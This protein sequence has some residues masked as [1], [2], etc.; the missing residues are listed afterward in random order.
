MTD[1]T[2]KRS[3][4]AVL[5][6]I[7]EATTHG[8]NLQVATRSGTVVKAT[9]ACSDI[10][11]SL[12]AAI[13]AWMRNT[14][15]PIP[16][17]TSIFSAGFG[18][19]PLFAELSPDVDTSLAAVI[20]ATA[21][22]QKNSDARQ[23]LGSIISVLGTSHHLSQDT[24]ESLMNAATRLHDKIISR[25][26]ERA[27]SSL[28]IDNSRGRT[29]SELIGAFSSYPSL[30]WDTLRLCWTS[31]A[32]IYGALVAR[33]DLE[34]IATYLPSLTDNPEY[35]RLY[36]IYTDSRSLPILSSNTSLYALYQMHFD[37]DRGRTFNT[38]STSTLRGSQKGLKIKPGKGKK[39][40]ATDNGDVLDPLP[41]ASAVSA[42][43]TGLDEKL[44]T[45]F[46]VEVPMQNTKHTQYKYWEVSNPFAGSLDIA[47]VIK[48]IMRFDTS[49]FGLPEFS[50]DIESALKAEVNKSAR[51][52]L[53]TFPAI[54][55][56][57]W[58]DPRVM[59]LLGYAG[60]SNVS[61]DSGDTMLSSMT[62]LID[63]YKPTETNSAHFVR[64]KS[65][66][67]V[68]V[69]VFRAFASLRNSLYEVMTSF[70]SF[71]MVKSENTE[72]G[73]TLVNSNLF[74]LS[75]IANYKAIYE[76]VIESASS[77]VL[78]EG[79]PGSLFH[80]SR[81]VTVPSLL[82][83]L[84]PGLSHALVL[85]PQVHF[86]EN[87]LTVRRPF[88]EV[89]GGNP[90]LMS[91]GAVVPDS[92]SRASA[93]NRL[94]AA[95][96]T[97]TVV[98]GFIEQ[99]TDDPFGVNDL[100]RYVALETQQAF[101]LSGR[102]TAVLRRDDEL[103]IQLIVAELIARSTTGF[104]DAARMKMLQNALLSLALPDSD[105][106]VTEQSGSVELI[107]K[108]VLSSYA[109]GVVRLQNG[110]EVSA[111]ALSVTG[112]F[113]DT[114]S[115]QF[116]FIFKKRNMYFSEDALSLNNAGSLPW[117]LFATHIADQFVGFSIND[118]MEARAGKV[119]LSDDN[120]FKRAY[121]LKPVL[122]EVIG[123]GQER[124]TRAS[125]VTV[126]AVESETMPHNPSN[127]TPPVS[128]ESGNDSNET[129]DDKG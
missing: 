101:S 1:N 123:F 128:T 92:G 18:S 36:H 26:F 118:V 116:V 56:D 127:A 82:D 11:F 106:V 57:L 129:E 70:D 19:P 68:M 38:L 69:A 86:A 47:T 66:I 4:S 52:A 40:D 84:N 59:L 55:P 28:M 95:A 120:P 72:S 122:E 112:S 45:L 121:N 43:F 51:P 13:F 27:V 99:L 39:G 49:V 29:G 31:L 62:A 90:T 65:H 91:S 23:D 83:V 61:V 12:D 21:L 78:I 60:L 125:T 109:P 14:S 71:S 94:A 107:R 114:G 30:S 88:L 17:L 76:A 93:F 124:V 100:T 67:R 73:L 25:G 110:T 63:A 85:H 80:V 50:V 22:S 9:P 89:I 33:T 104:L 15:I 77:Q 44:V 117:P 41:R 53:P 32:R 48:A 3:T 87:I 10:G 105:A 6:G 97:H 96:E 2:S 113:V 126:N 42:E 8:R 102:I 119:E 111:L 79:T 81:V 103:P 16:V 115:P 54:T 20:A 75:T 46:G 98:H 34:V 108:T 35:E 24:I 37:N 64:L 74:H 7:V 58:D 5:A